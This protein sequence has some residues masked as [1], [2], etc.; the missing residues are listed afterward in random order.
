MPASAQPTI[1]VII[2]ARYGSSRLPGKPLLDLAGKPMIR[3]VYERAMQAQVS[4][5]WV[6]TD[7]ARIHAAVHSFGGQVMMTATNHPSGTDRVAEVARSLKAEII[8]NV[9]GDEPLLD[10]QLINRVAEPLCQDPTLVM[11]TAAHPIYDQ[12]EANDP[13][14]VKVVCNRQGNALYFSR[15]PIPFDRDTTHHP[16][17]RHLGLY[18]YRASFLQK[19]ATLPPTILEQRERLEQ[20]RVLEE[21]YTIRVIVTDQA[22]I[23]VDTPADAE[24]VRGLL[25]R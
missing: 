15:S 7:D 12:N 1:A 9:Q 16:L 8:V 24:R 18:A 20:L 25:A 11:A 5:V 14:V 4:S 17:L 21:G 10:P 22:A 2:P 23:G 3:H 19:L 6:A 13:N